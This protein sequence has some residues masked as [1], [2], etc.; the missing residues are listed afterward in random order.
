MSSVREV[1]DGWLELAQ[2]AVRVLSPD[3]QE[4][5]RL[6]KEGW[7]LL[8]HP[9]LTDLTLL[10]RQFPTPVVGTLYQQFRDTRESI[11]MVVTVANPGDIRDRIWHEVALGMM[12]NLHYR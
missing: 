8:E 6:L 5:E 12:D 2:K 4:I 7:Q 10:H 11:R 3:D 1:G 9:S